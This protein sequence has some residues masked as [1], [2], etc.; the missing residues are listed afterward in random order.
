MSFANW[1]LG[2]VLVYSALFGIG[3]LVFGQ[4]LLG[5]SLIDVAIVAFVLI[6]WNLSRDEKTRAASVGPPPGLVP[7]PDAG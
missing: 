7:P 3:K 4:F 6:L 2:I 5:F 1:L